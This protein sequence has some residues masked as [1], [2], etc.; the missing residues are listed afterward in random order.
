MKVIRYF[1][2]ICLFL[3]FS[4]DARKK[5][6]FSRAASKFRDAMRPFMSDLNLYNWNQLIQDAEYEPGDGL[7]NE[8]DPGLNHNQQQNSELNRL[9]GSEAANM[10]TTPD[11]TFTD[12]AGTIPQ[13]ILDLLDFIENDEKFARFGIKPPRGI[14][15]VGPP[16]T[17]KTSLARA[18]AGEARCGFISTSASEF[19]EIYIGTGPLRVRQLFEQARRYIQQHPERKVII[20]ID[21]IDAIGSRSSMSGHD[22]ETRRTLNELL[23]QM[24][25]FKQHDSIIVL[26]ATNDPKGVDAALKR[27]GRFDTLVEVPLPNKENRRAVIQHYLNKIPAYRISLSVNVDLLA[28]KTQGLNNADLKEI[29][30]AA[31]VSAAREDSHFL[32]QHHLETAAA[33]IRYKKRY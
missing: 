10:P 8:L 2:F 30:R 33:S 4:A 18:I 17:G 26:A 21:D 32:T 28:T 25:G 12:I 16:G 27:A 20:F 24:D 6:W 22:T 29:V 9:M 31:T 19:I 13:D 5:T 15:L 11:F 1:F 23:N 3:P 7:D 14:L